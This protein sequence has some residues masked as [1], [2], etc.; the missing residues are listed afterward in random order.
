MEE[1]FQGVYK[2]LVDGITYPMQSDDFQDFLRH[3]KNEIISKC[4]LFGN[5]DWR[6]DSLLVEDLAQ[7]VCLEIHGSL[8]RFDHSLGTFKNWVDSISLNTVRGYIRK[9]ARKPLPLS[10]D[11]IMEQ[12]HDVSDELLLS[13]SPELVT[14][15]KE[16]HK[17]LRELMT[18]LQKTN[19]KYYQVLYYR[20]YCGMSVEEIATKLNCD[21]NSIYRITNRALEKLR[22]WVR[23][24]DTESANPKVAGGVPN[25]RG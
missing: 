22:K 20:A 17:L 5:F 7:Q 9:Q 8:H 13:P 1:R 15:E 3:I 24:I 23:E 16:K 4:S 12:G 14:L 19:L 10:L 2:S 25:D 6:E 11:N 21:P 18:K